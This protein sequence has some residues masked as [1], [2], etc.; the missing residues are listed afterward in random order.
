MLALFVALPATNAFGQ[1]PSGDWVSGIACQNLSAT[2][3]SSISIAFYPEGNG[4]AALTYNDPTPVPANGSRN[5][6]TPSSPPGLPDDFIG[7]AV[8]SSDQPMS[9]NVNTQTTGSGTV[10]DPYRLGTSAG[11]RET[12]TYTSAYVPQ[13]EKNYAGGWSSYIAI[14]NTGDDS[15]DVTINYKDRY[16]SNI[17]S[18]SETI[19]IPALSNYISYQTA[20]GNLPDNFLGSAT[21]TG[22][23]S[24]PLAIATSFYNSGADSSTSQMHS[25]N[26]FGSGANK[27]LIPR[28]VRN[29]YGY[30][31]GFAIQNVGGAATTVTINFH[32]AGNNYTYTSS[33]IAIG[34]SLFLYAPNIT[35][36]DPVDAL[37]ESQRSGSAEITASGGGSIIAIVNEDNRGGDG[38]PTERIGQGATYNGILSGEETSSVFFSQVPRK[39][40][41]VWSGGFVVSNTTDSPCTCDITYAN[42]PG[43]D[44]TDV[45]IS[46]KGSFSRYAPNVSGLPDGFNSSV[47]V[48]CTQNV[49]G[50]SNQA[51]ETGTGL[52]GDSYAQSNGLNQ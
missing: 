49:V 35:E 36:L 3:A 52:Y 7:S 29:Y 43:A 27:I 2:T 14:Q 22:D 44:E 9:C 1:A 11:V 41:G 51:V 20:N 5:Y 15:V 18:A 33:S 47:S 16:G 17:P 13:V 21:I 50:I 23:G 38:V 24:T 48:V 42:T 26:G 31:G 40:G 10:S 39:A 37:P 4:V 6:F 12:E 45:P 34:A 30:N 32:F 46:A 8:V 19:A 25:Y 28:F